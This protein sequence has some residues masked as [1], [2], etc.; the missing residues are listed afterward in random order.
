MAEA[1]HL[2]EKMK[3][4]EEKQIQ[5]NKYS[6]LEAKMRNLLSLTKVPSL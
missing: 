5:E 4:L 1:A 2:E 6:E 3:L